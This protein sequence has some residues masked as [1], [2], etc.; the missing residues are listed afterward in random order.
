MT[1][2]AL[3]ISGVAN[4]HPIDRHKPGDMPVAPALHMV[5]YWR[6]VTWHW[7]DL[8]PT[9]ARTPYL[10]VADRHGVSS[11]YRWKLAWTWY[12]RQV[13]AHKHYEKWRQANVSTYGVPSW[14]VGVQTS[15][16]G[17][18]LHCISHNEEYGFPGDPKGGYNTIAGY[19]GAPSP[20]SAYIEPGP[21]LAA[22][23]GDSWL[24]IPLAEQ[25]R[26]AWA[27]YLTYG[28]SPWSTAPGCG[29]S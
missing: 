14:F 26:W 27:M 17:T 22:T 24:S 18:A 9:A 6:D 10:W 23:Y 21:S 2:L 12:Y 3:S 29:L 4:A 25:V 28:W 16:G 1:C 8:D 13:A 7:Q 15:T 20:P 11:A 5:H 19:F